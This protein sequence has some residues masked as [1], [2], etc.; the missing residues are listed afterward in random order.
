V[1]SPLEGIDRRSWR[2]LA[3]ILALTMLSGCDRRSPTDPSQP[4]SSA[5][6][7]PSPSGSNVV[8]GVVVEAIDGDLRPIAGRRLHLWMAPVG[9]LGGWAQ[10]AITDDHGRYVAEVASARVFVNAWH[11]PDQEQPCLAS[12]A[13][14]GNTTLDVQVV[15]SG[16]FVTTAR[17]P[18]I[19]GFVYEATP[20]GRRPLSGVFATLDAVP[21]IEVPVATT[22]T[23]AA[24]RFVLCRV[25]TPVGLA[26]SGPGYAPWFQ[27]I[28][29][30][31][32]MTLDIELKPTR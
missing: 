13:V 5:G 25:D 26:V 6:R 9:G 7:P 14:N 21:F 28:P 22:Q 16:T 23:D 12:A 24:G 3:S 17:G 11:P 10:S 32:D 1:T 27:S 19:S 8:S 18:T 15:P 31:G 30:T 4:A 29:G 20:Q 2:L